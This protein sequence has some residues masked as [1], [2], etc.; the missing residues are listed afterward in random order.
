MSTKEAIAE[1]LAAADLK[2]TGEKTVSNGNK[3]TVHYVGRLNDQEVFDTSVES[4]AKAAG[5][6]SPARNYNEGLSFTVGAKQ[7]IAGFDK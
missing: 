5:K 1:Y 4:I 2:G 3:I 6:Y 7:M